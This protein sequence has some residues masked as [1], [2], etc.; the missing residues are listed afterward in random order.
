M[1]I[2]KPDLPKAEGLFDRIIQFSINNAIWVMMFVIAWIGV[3]IYSYQK[4]SIDAVPDI[5]NVQVQINSQANGFTAPEVEQ[6]ITYPI[7]NA[8]SGIPNLEQTR[9]ISRY[10]LSQV[11]I[12]FKD[13]TDIYWARQLINQRLQEAKSALPDS[14]DPQMSP[15]STGLGE[16]YQWVVKAEP[17]AKKADGSAYSAMDLREIQDWII[18]PQLQ[19]V[20]GVAEVNSIGGYNKTYVVSPDL[21]R[22]QQLQIPLTDLQDALQNNNENRG[23][24]FIEENGQQ[25]N[26]RVPGMLMSIQDIQ[27]VTVATKNGLPI[28]VADVASV[29][30]G[31]DLRT[32]GATYNGQE[33]VLGIAMMMMGENSKTIAKAID[34]KVQEIQRSL[35]QGVVIETVYDRSSLV[36]KAIK[37]VAKN[38]IEGAILVIVILF[39]FLGNFRA[40]LITACIIPLAM[41]FTLT[42]MA[43]QKISANLMSLGA[44]DFGIIV[45]GAVVIVENC[46]RRLAEAQHL[47]G[48]LLTRSERFTEVFLAAKQARRPLI[49][50]QIIIMV[51]YLPI[52]ALAGVEAKM[53]H[54]MAMTVVL[55]LLGAIILSVTF[56]PAAVALFITCEVKEKESRWMMTLKKGYAGLLDKAYAFRYVVVTAAVSILIL[57]SAIATRVGS[58]FAP[59]LSEGDFALQLMRAPSTGIEESLKIQENVEKQLLKA[60]P[61]I[62][63]IFARTGT[64]E[65]ATDVMPPNISDG[66]VLLKPHDQWP[67]PKE[68]IDELRTRMLQFVN[69][70]PGNNSEFSQPIELRFNELISG[71]RSDIG[72]KVFGDDMQVLNQEAEKI[73]QQLRSIPGASEVKVEQTDGLPLLN[74]D[75]NHALAAQYGLSV[76]SIQDIVAASIGGQSVGQILQGDRRFDFVIRLQENMRTPQQLAQLPIR[77]PNGGLIQLQDVAK[78]ENILGLAQVSRENGKRRVIVTANVRDRDLGSFVQEMQSKLAQQKL[79]SGY[80]LGYGGQF[81]N[82]ASATA[83]MQIV[84]PMA[85]IMIFVLLM[86]VFSNFKDSLLVFSGVPFALSGGLVALWLRDIPLSMSAGVGFIALSGVAVLNGLVMLTFI[87]ELRA[88]LDVHAATWKG[89]V[90]RLR[91]VLM[92]AFVASLGFIPMALATGTGAEV[93]R[94][95]ATVVIGGIISSTILT[96]VLLPVIYRWM[97]EDKTKSVEHS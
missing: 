56:V 78:V 86:A 37:T 19:R 8:M 16:I 39:I 91:P 74:V 84:V 88:T 20:Q 53:F 94:P 42:G 65:V 75:V 31:H 57:T 60:F 54:P 14:I 83:R 15:I 9:S 11:T 64:A 12:I 49:F 41:L 69:Q 55:A 4:L 29:S 2:N 62:K 46:I 17:N 80:W 32:G 89:A 82:L 25:L 50:G 7:E 61:E 73:A 26:V 79:P 1:D 93:Q 97:N 59:Q 67:N 92:T 36:D 6:R 70:I 68:T 10:G 51:V 35:P 66:I 85:L 40:A 18:R 43:E 63:A 96:L 27:N 44:L 48:R 77:L 34:D 3:G 23:A 5:T 81:E 30:I 38:L 22:L 52:F 33:T 87:K 13:G 76:K 95:L 28:R 21:T 58:E 90:L 72:V 45:D 24:G 47:K 71:V